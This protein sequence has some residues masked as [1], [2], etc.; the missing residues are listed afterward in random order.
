MKKKCQKKVHSCRVSKLLKTCKWFEDGT[1]RNKVLS[2][3]QHKNLIRGTMLDFIL[4]QMKNDDEIMKRNL[5]KGVINVWKFNNFN[6][7]RRRIRESCQIR[8]QAI[9]CLSKTN[10]KNDKQY[11]AAF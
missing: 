5:E 10:F 6:V 4:Y 1:I 3:K 8:F 9:P 7:L 2:E 11:F